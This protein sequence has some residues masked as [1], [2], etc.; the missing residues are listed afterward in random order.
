[1]SDRAPRWSS[2]PLHPFL[3]AILPVLWLHRTNLQSLYADMLLR[4][5]IACLLVAGVTLLV[6]A[7]AAGGARRAA[8]AATLWTLLLLQGG[9]VGGPAALALAGLAAATTAAARR[10]PAPWPSVSALMNVAAG[11]LVVFNL[12]Q[13]RNEAAAV[14]SPEIRA[15]HLESPLL[16][17]WTETETAALPDIYYLVLDGMGRLDVLGELYDLDPRGMRR[18][19]G[20][21]DLH[22][23]ERSYANYPQTA[24]SLASALNMERLEG[25]LDFPEPR[26][27]DRRPVGET[28][29]RSRVAEVLRAHGY[30]VVDYPSGYPFT[31]MPDADEHRA[32]WLSL[33]LAELYLLNE[34]LL[35]PLQTLVADGPSELSFALRRRRIE[36][37]FDDL[38][39][40]AAE[41]SEQPRFVF[42]HVLAPHPPF[43]FGR[44]GEGLPSRQP[45]SYR[46]GDHWAEVHDDD[47]D[48]RALYRDQALYVL[49]RLREAIAGILERSERPPVIV[50]QG[51]HGPG[52]LLE[53][54]SP[55]PRA[56]QERLAIFHAFHLPPGL[57]SSLYP[58]I[59]PVNSFRLIFNGLFGPD[60]PPA[61]DRVFYSS[62][63]RPF[64][65]RDL[66]VIT[67]ED[68]AQ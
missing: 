57:E 67:A 3:A 29:A 17:R 50:V 56:L 33:D 2:L 21:L 23:A 9:A 32:P 38:P 13:T 27:R 63:G 55:S 37:V 59:T 41:R 53:W 26:A 60:A 35:T 34:T 11:V 20:A 52:S 19:L 24:L 10:W 28:V 47:A 54:A 12:V 16:E 61:E 40:L 4:P 25:F 44:Y 51:D 31:R 66:G 5:L 45:F 49:D 64:L 22:I 1:M 68:V 42:A 48:Y 43:V 14:V 65:L 7:G 8:P 36:H 46:D 39:R 6:C 15:E 58:Q 18:H 62:I 30:R